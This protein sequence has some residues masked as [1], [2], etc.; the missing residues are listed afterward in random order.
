MALRTGKRVVGVLV[1]KGGEKVE[2]RM[3][4]EVQEQCQCALSR[5]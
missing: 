1:F 4:S 3:A 2:I 5:V